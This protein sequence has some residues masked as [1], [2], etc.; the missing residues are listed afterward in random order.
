MSMSATR[1]KW[2]RVVVITIGAPL[3][4]VLLLQLG[5]ASWCS[6]TAAKDGP[7]IG[8]SVD[9][10]WHARLG[11]TT[12]SYKVAIT[13]AGG[14]T[15]MFRHDQLAPAELLDRIDAL[16]LAGGG[17][18]AAELSGSQGAELVIRARDEFEAE[19]IRGAIARDMPVLAI[20]R[21][22]QIVNVTHGGTLQSIRT[23][24]ARAGYHGSKLAALDHDHAAT[25]RNDSLLA[26]I[27]GAGRREVD[28]YHGQS[29][30]RLGADLVAVAVAGDGLIE[31]VERTDQSFFVA[32]QWHPELLS[33]SDREELS[34][35]SAL[36]AAGRRYAVAH[37]RPLGVS[38]VES[39]VTAPLLS[40][41]L[42]WLEAAT[43]AGER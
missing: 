23:D 8:V 20:C 19:L 7:L 31:A 9:S 34:L 2:R 33:I 43:D 4:L 10:A 38:D 12:A 3:L 30:D 36:V 40:R 18:V 41:Q 35:F 1:K 16:L 27:V 28:S 22:L 42:A 5:F 24:S 17:D 15:F 14:K 21:G 37:P 6:L 26:S 39:L 25:V 13:R 32:V 29:V 11:V